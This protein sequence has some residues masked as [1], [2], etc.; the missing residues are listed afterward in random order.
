M[1]ESPRPPASSAASGIEEPVH[2]RGPNNHRRETDGNHRAGALCPG[3]NEGLS[4]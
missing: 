3:Q 2:R 4:E 1:T